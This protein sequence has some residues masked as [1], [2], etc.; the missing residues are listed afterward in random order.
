MSKLRENF[1][2]ENKGK[3]IKLIFGSGYQ[4][5]GK[6]VDFDEEMIKISTRAYSPNATQNV[7]V[8]FTAISTYVPSVE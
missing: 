3:W 7:L 1:L 6:L 8:P 4:L 2:A 5:N